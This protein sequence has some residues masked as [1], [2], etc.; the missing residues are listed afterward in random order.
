MKKGRFCSHN[1][2]LSVFLCSREFARACVCVGHAS[3]IMDVR[4]C[5]CALACV[6]ELSVCDVRVQLHHRKGSQSHSMMRAFLCEYK[7]HKSHITYQSH[8]CDR[9]RIVVYKIIRNNEQLFM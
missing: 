8:I 2:R 1:C 5:Q 7:V 9:C 3:T 6:S 4:Q